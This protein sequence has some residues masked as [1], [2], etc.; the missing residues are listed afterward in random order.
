MNAGFAPLEHLHAGLNQFPSLFRAG[1]RQRLEAPVPQAVVIDKEFLDLGQEMVL[2]ASPV[3]PDG[4][5]ARGLE[6]AGVRITSR[7]IAYAVEPPETRLEW[8]LRWRSRGKTAE[9]PRFLADF[10]KRAEILSLEWRT[11]DADR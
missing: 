3:P 1:I 11:Q 8:A 4:D 10:A 5:L 6:S 7:S 2:T 9:P